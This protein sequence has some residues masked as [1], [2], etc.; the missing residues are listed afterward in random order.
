MRDVIGYEEIFSVTEDGEVY[1]KR[2]NRFLIQGTTKTGYKVISSRIGGRRGKAI[3]LRVHRLVAEAFIPNFENK[4]HVNH[5][6]GNKSNNCISNLEW[7]NEHENLQHA[8]DF[9]L[10]KSDTISCENNVNSKL[11]K[12]IVHYIRSSYI[13][14]SSEFGARA[15]SRKF[16]VN[17]ETVLDI[18]H[19]KTWKI[20]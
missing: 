12:D 3:C 14:R 7:V 19:N 6:D 2:T 10:R 18:V 13:S 11:T 5:K 4:P 17:K 16:G 8:W 1:S 20:T 15:L 9:G